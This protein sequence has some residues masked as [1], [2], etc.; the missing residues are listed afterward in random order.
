MKEIELA[1]LQDKDKG[2]IQ[3]VYDKDNEIQVI[4]R[5][6]EKEVKLMKEVA[7]G[8]CEWKNKHLWYEG[9]IWIPN[10]EGL[11]MSLMEKN[12]DNPLAGH[13]GTAK[14]QR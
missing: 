9:K 11:R 4:R 8:L 7:L 2:R 5:D 1:E 13:G 3:E 6:L 10:N 12:H 14:R